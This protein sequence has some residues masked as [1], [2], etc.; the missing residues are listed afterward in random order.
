[1]PY[2]ARLQ[3]QQQQQFPYLQ[4]VEK[5]P[6]GDGGD[7]K[8]GVV[9]SGLH[10]RLVGRDD[11]LLEAREHH[12]RPQAAQLS[13]QPVKRCTDDGTGQEANSLPKSMTDG[14]ASLKEK[15][16]A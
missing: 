2:T 10:V 11:H 16:E 6:R 7:D 1:M 13:D 4:G 14:T 8:L 3:Q 12:A 9:P 5:V 15:N